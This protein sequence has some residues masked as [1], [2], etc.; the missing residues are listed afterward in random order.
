MRQIIVSICII[1][2]KAMYRMFIWSVS[3][4]CPAS[5]MYTHDIQDPTSRWLL[6]PETYTLIPAPFEIAVW[7][8]FLSS[9]CFGF[10]NHG[11]LCEAKQ[12]QR[13]RDQELWKLPGGGAEQVFFLLGC[14]AWV[15]WE[16]KV[17][18]AHAAILMILVGM[19][20]DWPIHTY[21]IL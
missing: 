15:A 13:S 11:K 8:T 7:W 16:F 21:T 9:R 3:S 19:K 4:R 14:R 2:A 6:G 12:R 18:F 1:W 17:I 5:K 10:L 20:K